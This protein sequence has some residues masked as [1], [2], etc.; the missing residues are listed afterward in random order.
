MY[1]KLHGVSKGENSHHKEKKKKKKKR[2]KIL[3]NKAKQKSVNNFPDSFREML[4]KVVA[5]KKSVLN[6]Q[7]M[8]GLAKFKGLLGILIS[9][10]HCDYS[11]HKV[12]PFSNFSFC[13]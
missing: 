5:R 12:K 11:R 9:N 2:K 7:E 13:S 1:A 6:L 4:C 3:N 10:M 8:V